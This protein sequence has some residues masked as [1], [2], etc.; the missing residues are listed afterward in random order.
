MALNRRQFATGG[1]VAAAATLG[2]AKV[3]A[4]AP[5]AERA[6]TFEVTRS[7]EEWRRLLTPAQYAVLRKSKTEPAGSSPLDGEKRAG[8]FHCAGCDLPLFSSATKFDSGTGWPSFW[9]PLDN[10]IG[11]RKEVFCSSSRLRSIAGAAAVTSDTCSTTARSPPA[12]AIA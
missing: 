12:C 6:S 8:T 3:C 2:G 7:D 10:A 4:A 9:Q 5:P 11:T 1:A